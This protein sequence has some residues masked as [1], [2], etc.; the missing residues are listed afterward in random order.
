MHKVGSFVKF[1]GSLSFIDFEYLSSQF[2]QN[3]LIDYIKKS[4]ADE[5]EKKMNEEA[6]SLSREQKSFTEIIPK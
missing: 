4:Q 5:I 3:G 1:Y 6:E 2:E